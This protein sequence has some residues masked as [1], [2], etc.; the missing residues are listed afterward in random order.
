[1]KYLY[2]MH[3]HTSEVSGCGRVSGADS[4]VFYKEKGYA[5]IIVTDHMVP[6]AFRGMEDASWDEKVDRFMEGYKKAVQAA[7]D[8]NFDVILSMELRFM[9]ES[10]N[11]YLIYGFTEE[12]LRNNPEPYNLTLKQFKKIADENGFL[13]YQAHPFRDHMTVVD[14]KYLHGIE[15]H[16]GHHG[17]DSRNP[18]AEAW[19]ELHGLPQ[20]S[21][22]DYHYLEHLARGGMLFYERIRTPQDLVK[23]LKSGRYGLFKGGF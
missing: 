18:I 19:A 15:V 7:K 20:S 4:A 14:P 23:Q 22:S 13:I 16:N 9:S 10:E 11:D 17:H 6:R 5:G 2:E 1:M 12:W 3:L 8:E 21:G